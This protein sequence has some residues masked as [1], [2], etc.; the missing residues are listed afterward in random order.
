MTRTANHCFRSTVADALEE[1]EHHFPTP[2]GLGFK[3]SDSVED[4]YSD[5]LHQLREHWCLTFEGWRTDEVLVFMCMTY[6]R[7]QLVVLTKSRRNSQFLRQIHDEWKPRFEE[8]A[9]VLWRFCGAS[10]ELFGDLIFLLPES[11][12][13]SEAEMGRALFRDLVRKNVI[14]EGACPDIAGALIEW[15]LESTLGINHA[16]TIYHLA[17]ELSP[18]ETGFLCRALVLY[19]SMKN[20]KCGYERNQRECLCGGQSLAFDPDQDYVTALFPQILED[21]VVTKVIVEDRWDEDQQEEFLRSAC[22][23]VFSEAV[24]NEIVHDVLHGKIA[25]KTQLHPRELTNRERRR[26]PQSAQRKP[27]MIDHKTCVHHRC[28]QMIKGGCKNL[29]CKT[30]CKAQGMLECHIHRHYIVKPMPKYP[31]RKSVPY[32]PETGGSGSVG[33]QF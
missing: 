32:T 24:Y 9:N 30:H 20:C 8:W 13:A 16:K 11:Q 27:H 12:R 21:H 15:P 23:Y 22:E 2:R 25:Q 10:H 17:K 28:A 4:V 31:Q 18:E 19:R 26:R 6:P 5:R 14:P 1:W 33:A 29:S 7:E 3:R